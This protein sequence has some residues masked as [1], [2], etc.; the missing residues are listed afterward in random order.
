MQVIGP[1]ILDAR[2]PD[3]RS[4]A[5]AKDR[6]S[7]PWEMS[8][9]F[10][11]R[12]QSTTIRFGFWGLFSVAMQTAQE[13]DQV[14]T[15][16]DILDLLGGGERM[17]INETWIGDVT[18]HCTCVGDAAIG[19]TDNGV[20]AILAA[21]N[22]PPLYGFQTDITIAIPGTTVIANAFTGSDPDGDP[23][24]IRLSG[25][26]LPADAVDYFVDPETGTMTI[27]VSDL[28]AQLIDRLVHDSETKKIYIYDL[29]PGA[30]VVSG[31]WPAEGDYYHESYQDVEITYSVD[32]PPRARN[33]DQSRIADPIMLAQYVG[34]HPS[35]ISVTSANPQIP[36]VLRWPE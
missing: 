4:T 26:G 29:K 9:H 33:L 6:D 22:Q 28:D 2:N 20:Q 16:Q 13:S 31:E 23:L 36:R 3:E 8:S 12:G 1:T 5:S 14:E 17:R 24:Y 32:P 18:P 19:V 10:T 11:I 34:G 21:V 27:T 25:H 7:A 30:T 35:I 15:Q